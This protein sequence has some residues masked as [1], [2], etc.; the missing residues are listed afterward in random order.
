MTYYNT[1]K[2]SGETLKESQ[3]K[4]FSQEHVILSYIKK[5]NGK[6]TSPSLLSMFFDSWPMTSIRRALTNLTNK[7]YL[8]KTDQMV[9]GV[10]GKKE[11]VW[12]LKENEFKETLF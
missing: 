6:V 12:K 5:Q 1:N 2:E 8:I 3:V 10:Y 4:A 9:D 7:G 11:H